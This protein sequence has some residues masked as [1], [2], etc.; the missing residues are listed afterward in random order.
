MQLFRVECVHELGGAL[1]TYRTEMLF[2]RAFGESLGSVGWKTDITVQEVPEVFAHLLIDR[3]FPIADP[4]DVMLDMYRRDPD[5]YKA[6]SE[7]KR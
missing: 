4:H 3:I 5:L 2:A 1:T 6:I 7:G